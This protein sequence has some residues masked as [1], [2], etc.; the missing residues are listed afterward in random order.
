[1]KKLAILLSAVAL[2]AVSAM[3]QGNFVFQNNNSFPIK[4]Q[5]PAINGG[6][7]VNIGTTATAAGFVGAGQSQVT[8][9]LYVAANGTSLAALEASTPVGTT[10][11]SSSGV[12]LFQGTFN[13]GNPF[14]LPA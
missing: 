8:I 7:A 9:T 14:V 3:A 4:V 10:L 13:G 1:M 12:A 6:T 11:N 5:D 2:G